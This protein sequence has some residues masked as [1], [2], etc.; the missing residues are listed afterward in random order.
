VRKLIAHPLHR[1]N[2]DG[3]VKFPGDGAG[4]V[5]Y[6]Q[7]SI[8]GFVESRPPASAASHRGRRARTG[9]TVLFG[10]PFVML[11]VTMPR[12][13]LGTSSTTAMDHAGSDRAG[14]TGKWTVLVCFCGANGRERQFTARLP[15]TATGPWLAAAVVALGSWAELAIGFDRAWRPDRYYQYYQP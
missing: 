7:V 2:G 15:E 13:R 6:E 8:I 4:F 12:S 10:V 5:D 1:S 11:C 14:V 9:R 3:A